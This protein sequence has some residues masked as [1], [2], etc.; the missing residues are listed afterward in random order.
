MC[1][2]SKKKLEILINI[3][4]QMCRLHHNVPNSFQLWFKLK[5]HLKIIRQE[6]LYETL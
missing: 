1:Y 5:M 6:Y 2:A 3:Q 4:K